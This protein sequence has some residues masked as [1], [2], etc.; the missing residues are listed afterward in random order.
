MRRLDTCQVKQSR[1]LSDKA[2]FASPTRQSRMPKRLA[3]AVADATTPP[4]TKKTKSPPSVISAAF[5]KYLGRWEDGTKDGG[6]F[7]GKHTPDNR[8]LLQLRRAVE[9]PQ[10]KRSI[11]A[12][13]EVIC[14]YSVART[15]KLGKDG[16]RR[17][18]MLPPVLRFLQRRWLAV[19][20]ELATLLAERCIAE[21]DRLADA[22]KVHVGSRNLCAASKLW[23]L[24]GMATPIYDTVAR[25]QLFKS[26][27]AMEYPEYHTRWHEH[28]EPK[29]RS[30]EAAADAHDCPAS[31]L[32]T[33]EWFLMRAF[34]QFLLQQAK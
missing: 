26:I 15:M 25:G 14:A 30:Y 22:L 5:E 11:D 32:V 33:R 21:V 16:V 13:Y 18:K 17:D 34:D 4:A 28:F 8:L 9:D 12:L 19:R 23:V 27:A 6:G 1:T 24:L 10:A 29:R 7:T 31:A 3:A 2:S 20:G